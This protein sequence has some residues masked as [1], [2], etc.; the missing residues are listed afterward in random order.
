MQRWRLAAAADLEP[1]D[2]PGCRAHSRRRVCLGTRASASCR[3]C[4]RPSRRRGKAAPARVQRAVGWVHACMGVC[5][6]PHAPARRAHACGG[7]CIGSCTQ[8]GAYVVGGERAGCVGG[9][10]LG[11]GVQAAGKVG[12]KGVQHGG[13][14]RVAGADGSRKGG[15][16]GACGRGGRGPAVLSV[17][18]AAAGAAAHET[19]CSAHAAPMRCHAVP[20]G[21]R[22]VP[23]GAMRRYACCIYLP[24]PPRTRRQV[25]GARI[26]VPAA[27]R[28]MRL[29][30]SGGGEQ[31]AAEERQEAGSST[32]PP[33]AM[34]RRHGLVCVG[35][36]KVRARCR[37]AAGQGCAWRRSSWSSSSWRAA[38]RPAA[39]AGRP[40]AP[41]RRPAWSG[42][43]A[44]TCH[45]SLKAL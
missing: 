29:D 27:L 40:I 32:P 43:V 19:P 42:Q 25:A 23:C 13:L 37:A 7:S 17:S 11:G 26:S 4:G 15:D 24:Q 35:A 30:G 44:D 39:A 36:I 3:Q 14:V 31:Q 28:S 2:P 20:C 33:E 5:H 18:M 21:A 22:A 16:H 9:A 45:D 34:R 12:C 10:G 8:E 38:R 6:S 1:A 41:G